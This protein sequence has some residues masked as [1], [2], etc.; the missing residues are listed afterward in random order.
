MTKDNPDDWK[1]WES[2]MQRRRR[3]QEEDFLLFAITVLVSVL[4]VCHM[5]GLWR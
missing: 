1:R 4:A 3:E 5:L 2:K